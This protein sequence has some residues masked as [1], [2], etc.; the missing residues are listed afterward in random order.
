MYTTRNIRYGHRV[1]ILRIRLKN[2]IRV[3]GALCDFLEY[4]TIYEAWRRHLL[5]N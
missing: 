5:R 1:T 3:A 4:D 2:G